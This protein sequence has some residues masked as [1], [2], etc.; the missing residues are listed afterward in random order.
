MLSPSR[1]RHPYLLWTALV[2]GLGRAGVDYALAARQE[3]VEKQRQPRPIVLEADE[4]LG[5]KSVSSENG[6]SAGE[7]E[8]DED[9]GVNGEELRRA[10]EGFRVVQ[11]VRAGVTGLAF[12]MGVVGV[13]GDRGF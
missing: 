7:D 10:M 8:D 3:V 4:E 11:G 5:V 6:Y 2:A 12:A 1:A 9:E 13:W